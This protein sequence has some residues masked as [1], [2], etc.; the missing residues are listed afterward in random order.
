MSF[1]FPAVPTAEKKTEVPL[2][3]RPPNAVPV[4]M[5]RHKIDADTRPFGPLLFERM[6]PRYQLKKAKKGDEEA[7]AQPEKKKKGPM[8]TLSIDSNMQIDEKMIVAKLIQ[9]KL[10]KTIRTMKKERA[11]AALRRAAC[12][13]RATNRAYAAETAARQYHNMPPIV[14]QGRNCLA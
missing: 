5:W 8:L 12:K 9:T 1:A 2:P 3:K 14:A 7:V 13:A 11:K 10:F 4:Y 6:P